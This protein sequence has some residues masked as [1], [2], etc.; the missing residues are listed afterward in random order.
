MIQW[1]SISISE[2]R[3]KIL[4]SSGWLLARQA[5]NML[6]TLVLGI[7]IA[8]H[9][10]PEEFGV[11]SYATSLV[12][13][14]APLTTLGL[15]NL[16]LREYT[17]KPEEADRILGTVAV[18]RMCGALLAV[19]AAY[20]VATRFPIEHENIAMLCVIL[21]GAV[22]F[23]TFDT[24]QEHFIADQNP[25]PF[26]VY[27]VIIL[28]AFSVIKIA[29]IVGDG[30]VNAFIMTNAAQTA[31][32]GVGIAVAYRR[33]R[34]SF[35]GF[36]FEW[37]R[38]KLYARQGFPLMLGAMSAVIYLKIDILFLS[39]MA[40][41]EVT[42]LYS[43]AARLSEA[44]Y[45][46]PAT[47]ALA[48]FPRMVQLR[49]ESPRRYR[50]RMQ[51]A[52]DLFAAFGTLVAITSIFWAEPLIALLFGAPYVGSVLVLQIYVW[53]GIVFAT[54]SLLHK[55]L[56][57]EGFFWGSAM[58]NMTGAVTNI[59]LNLLLIPRYGA[60]GAAVA[61]VLSYTLAPL[62]LAPLVPGLRPVAA[63]QLKAIAWPRRVFWPEGR[64][65]AGT[66]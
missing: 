66:G 21:A 65:G 48:A 9:L 47:L 3:G 55:W 56:L 22:L 49:A 61:T 35:P 33:N 64:T 62:L 38:M 59:V 34:G 19:A 7:L 53:V 13:V 36:K 1:R 43:V 52:L 57:A 18:M 28:L 8:R 31:A 44:W 54:R 63:M 50:R 6:N 42:G 40:G 14:L 29:L 12:A 17:Q 15:R 51:D 4:K 39:N 45:A 20:Y 37:S 24:I 58:I 11:L 26:V 32:Q 10:G 46:L 25:R 2:A 16:S 23:R 41:K 60:E 30:S 27:S 5:I